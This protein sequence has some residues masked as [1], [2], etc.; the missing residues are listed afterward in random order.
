MYF[1]SESK[2]VR[3]PLRDD[4]KIGYSHTFDCSSVDDIPNLP[5]MPQILGG[6]TALVYVTGQD[7]KMYKCFPDGWRGPF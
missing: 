5:R 4:V 1:I 6:C 3:D 7:V 2:E